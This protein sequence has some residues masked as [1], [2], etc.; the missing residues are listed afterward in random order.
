MGI[1]DN[2]SFGGGDFNDRH[3]AELAKPLRAKI[4]VQTFERHYQTGKSG[5]GI[6]DRIR[7]FPARRIALFLIGILNQK[8]TL[9]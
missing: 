5:E 8:K 2:A 7:I 9:Q 6:G 1:P 4:K 3:C